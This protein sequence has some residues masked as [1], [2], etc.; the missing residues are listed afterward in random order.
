[1]TRPR[2]IYTAHAMIRSRPFHVPS[3][4]PR[5][6][7]RR[8]VPHAALPALLA[9]LTVLGGCET[10]DSIF[11]GIKPGSEGI[12]Q[13]LFTGPTPTEAVEM[14]VDEYDADRRYQGTNLLANAPFAG[15]PVYLDLFIANASDEDPAVRSASVRGLANHGNPSHVPL[16]VER[17]RDED[18]IVRLEAARALQRIHNPVAIDALLLAIRQGE[19]VADAEPDAQVRAEAADA[20][21]QYAENRVV[22]ALVAALADESFL[23]TSTARRSLRTLTGQDLGTDRKAWSAWNENATDTFA[24]RSVYRFPGYERDR[25]M[26]EYLPF[27]PQPPRQAPSVPVGMPPP[28]SG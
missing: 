13:D 22:R 2:F 6:G 20:L 27:M 4:S 16:L 10:A 28:G 3:R 11:S 14:S 26:V 1:M 9:A 17:L 25:T 7:P 19:L 23:V 15:E 8:A 21:G 18:R 24:A 5:R 12:L